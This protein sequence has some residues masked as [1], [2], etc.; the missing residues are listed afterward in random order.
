MNILGKRIKQLRE[1]NHLNQIEL[2]KTLNISNTTLS[3]YETGQRVPSD[4]VKIKICKIF[5]VTLDYLLGVSE[6]RNYETETIAA[7]H[8][9]EE[10][11]NEELE[12]IEAFKEFVKSRRNK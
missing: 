5:N 2:A 11:T 1:E 3:Q 10:F 6:T 8:D 9:G 4:D 12:E 7:H